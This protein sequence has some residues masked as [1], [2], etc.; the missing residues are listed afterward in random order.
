MA[1]EA[2]VTPED[3][4]LMPPTGRGHAAIRAVN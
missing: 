4:T 3:R 2:S 1:V